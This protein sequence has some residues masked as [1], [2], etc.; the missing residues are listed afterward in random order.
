MSNTTPLNENNI[1]LPLWSLLMAVEWLPI[2]DGIKHHMIKAEIVYI[3]YCTD[4]VTHVSK[5]SNYTQILH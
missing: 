4:D 3:I 2:W 5:L 1:W